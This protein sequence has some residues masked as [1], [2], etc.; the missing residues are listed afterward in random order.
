MSSLGVYGSTAPVSHDEFVSVLVMLCFKKKGLGN[1]LGNLD[2]EKEGYSLADFE[3]PLSTH[4]YIGSPSIT[5]YRLLVI[6]RSWLQLFAEIE[7]ATI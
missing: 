3:S 5:W 1:G 2:G 7:M 6:P 4:L